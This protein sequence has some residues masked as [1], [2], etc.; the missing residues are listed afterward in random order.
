MIGGLEAAYLTRTPLTRRWWVSWLWRTRLACD[1]FFE[2][3]LH[4]SRESVMAAM[5]R[6][7]GNTLQAEMA[8]ALE[9][10][11]HIARG[12]LDNIVEEK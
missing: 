5:Q 2:I 7:L 6:R 11:G 12:R 10:I 3:R 9:Q 1:G 8:A 4:A